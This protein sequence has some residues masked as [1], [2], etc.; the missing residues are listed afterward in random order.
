MTPD[1][2]VAH[3]ERLYPL[4]CEH[5]Q[6]YC[7]SHPS[8]FRRSKQ[9]PAL[10]FSSADFQGM[11]EWLVGVMICRKN[12]MRKGMFTVVGIQK[13]YVTRGKKE[14][15]GAG[16]YLGHC[17]GDVVI[18]REYPPHFV[19]RFRERFIAPK[20]IVQPTFTELV[21][22]IITEDFFGMDYTFSGVFC[23]LEDGKVQFEY[24]PEILHQKG[25]Q[26]LA[27]FQRE[28]IAYGV[29]SPNRRYFCFTTYVGDAD[30]TATQRERL[31]AA[32]RLHREHEF[33]HQKDPTDDATG[34]ELVDPAKR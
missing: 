29:A 8:I 16:F 27:S 28:G 5:G 24:I 10:Y 13:F 15:I 12:E 18:C 33:R 6:A 23:G 7:R 26:D 17:D 3:M 4:L 25:Y 1:E 14:N 30:L 32:R 2:K 9:F 31:S 19:N 11:G 22:R 21:R 20:G 34:I